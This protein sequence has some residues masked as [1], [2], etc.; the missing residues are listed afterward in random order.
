MKTI[1]ALLTLV[2]V[3]WAL[4]TDGVKVVPCKLVNDKLYINGK[5]IKHKKLD[6]IEVD[7]ELKV[8]YKETK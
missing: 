5:S 1:I 3:K 2:S 8:F 4:C 6:V 7:G